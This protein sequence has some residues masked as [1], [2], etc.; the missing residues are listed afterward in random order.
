MREKQFELSRKQ[1]AELER[2]YK[3]Q[4]DRR[5]AE[6]IQCIFLLHG[7]HNALR[8][9]KM[10][11]VSSKT[12]KRW[13][14]IFV[15]FGIEGLCTL[16]YENSGAVCG[17]TDVQQN[18]LE[19][20]LDEQIRCSAKEVMDYIEKEF[21]IKYTESGVL[22]LLKRMNY[23]YKKPAVVPSRADVKEQEAFVCGYTRGKK[24]Y[25]RRWQGLLY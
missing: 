4:R 9:A 23:T 7:G 3:Q 16:K 24:R 14:R 18:Q 25:R 22:K 11:M 6:R 21:G 17:I 15:N 20:Y 13:I 10:L 5:V 2:R 12:I 1:R 8:V 19:K